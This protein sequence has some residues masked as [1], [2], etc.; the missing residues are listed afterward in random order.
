MSDTTP[1]MSS[2]EMDETLSGL[3][4]A[5]LEKHFSKAESKTNKHF[6]HLEQRLDSIQMDFL[7]LREKISALREEHVSL[8]RHAEKVENASGL[9]I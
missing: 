6:K 1:I 5:V 3:N 4:E 2:V 9:L 7:A 8:K